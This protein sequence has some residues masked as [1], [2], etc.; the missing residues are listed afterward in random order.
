MREAAGQKQLPLAIF[1]IET[2]SSTWTRNTM[3]FQLI[4][5]VGNR[6]RWKTKS[7]MS[8][9]SAELIATQLSECEGVTG[10]SVNPRTGSV[11]VTVDSYAAR[12]RVAAY[13]AS[14]VTNPPIKRVERRNERDVH[15][16]CEAFVT[17]KP[18]TRPMT[19]T[20]LLMEVIKA[21]PLV[22]TFND[23][24]SSGWK[25]MPLATQVLNPVGKSL[26]LIKEKVEVV[27]DGANP[28]GPAKLDFGSLARFFI[29]NRFLPLV[30][31]TANTFLGAI[32]IIFN[33]VKELLHGRLNVDV[34]DAAAVGISILRRDWRTTGLTILLLGIGEMLDEYCRKKSM[35]SLAEQLS[36]KCDQVWVRRG[37]NLVQ[38][39]IQD[40]TLDD[41]VVVRMGSV[42]PVDGVVVAGEAAVNQA[43]M[44]GEAVAVHRNEGG[45]V[46]AGCVVEDGE[47]DIRPTHIGEGTRLAKIIKFV[48][49]SEQ[50]K[51]GIESKATKFADAIVPFNFALA[52]LVFFF[53]RDLNRTAAVLMVDYSC[54]IRLATPLAIL[55][56]MKEGTAR[57]ALI[58]G[59]RYLEALSQVDT[60]VFD[61]TGTLTSSQPTLSDVV[62]IKEGLSA[63]ELLRVAACLEEN[64][65]H[66]VSRA[67][68]KAADEKGLD[69]YEEQH[70]TQVDYVVAHGI[71]SK[72]DGQRVILGS[73]HFVEDDEKVDCSIAADQIKRLANE[74]K[75]VLFVAWSGRLIGLLGI[76]DPV[77]PEAA[78]VIKKLRERGKRIVMLTGDDER[79]AKAVAKRLGIEEYRAQVLPSDKADKVLELKREGCKVLMVGDGINDSPAL[80]SADVGATLRDSTDI[81]QEVAD[82]VLESSLEHLLMAL[83]LGEATMRR[84]KQNVGTSVAL[85]TGFLAGG[86]FGV[87]T[88]VMSAV[89]H[90]TTTILVCLNSMRPQLGRYEGDKS[91]F[92]KTWYDAKALCVNVRNVFSD[93][94][95]L[96]PYSNAKSIVTTGSDQPATN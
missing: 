4:H 95:I 61:K 63:D 39:P 27:E 93:Q 21:N 60:V 32:P 12:N 82:V 80:S 73:R 7:V 13:L 81:A 29:I 22:Q 19:R 77:R 64:F 59:G 87:L 48:E 15:L 66:P 85:N 47:I 67:V 35:S 11:I 53:T 33:G 49:E 88:P 79:T 52:A 71:C 10:V 68:V 65:P 38:I 37:E 94:P 40:M 75:T 43:T 41:V 76:E 1:S 16:Q 69:H 44:T 23:A 31:S 50:A 58:K 72:I 78:D 28:V 14:L 25:N 90:N 30:I 26:G 8:R 2:S 9:A 55:S 74:G 70:D 83:D 86:L 34:L 91:L 51:A 5:E 18:V 96:L 24:M 6:Q 62:P 57:G 20:Q 84:I 3:Q 36:I 17:G 89:L 46:F 54:A 92:E 42:I 45:S 56:A